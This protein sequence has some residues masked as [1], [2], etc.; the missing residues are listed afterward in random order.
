[1]MSD[2][3][4]LLELAAVD[5]ALDT[6]AGRLADLPEAKAVVA[7]EVL[8]RDRAKQLD[9][10]AEV[11]TDAERSRNRVEAEIE[12]LDQRITAAN[13][14]LSGGDVTN[15][16]EL[17]ALSDDVVMLE[18]Q[19]STIEDDEL[20]LLV[21]IDDLAS[22][23]DEVAG[24]LEALKSDIVGLQTERD[25][26]VGELE[27]ERA[28]LGS[29]REAAAAQADGDALRV[30][31]RIRSKR[32]GQAAAPLVGKVCQACHLSLAAQELAE[33]TGAGVPRCPSCEVI[34]VIGD[35]E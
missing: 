2:L 7:A 28:G 6:I 19:K 30:Y 17:S 5:A 16:R 26:V 9:E 21:T 33:V 8:I 3:P 13:E 20:E 10:V 23:R 34:L 4:P 15:P 14:R 25:R 27:T 35:D 18:R 22:R 12:R 11:L 24:E 29:G 1:M 32:G 31:D